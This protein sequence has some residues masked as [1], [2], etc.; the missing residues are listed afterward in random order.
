MGT[1]EAHYVRYTPKALEE[2]E[3]F[4]SKSRIVKYIIQIYSIGSR[5]FKKTLYKSLN[6]GLRES[7]KDLVHLLQF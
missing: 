3:G 6:S 2:E 1:N 5:R 4:Q 7:P